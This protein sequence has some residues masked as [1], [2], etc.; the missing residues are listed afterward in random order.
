MNIEQIFIFYCQKNFLLR[1]NSNCPTWKVIWS[2]KVQWK[3]G[4]MKNQLWCEKKLK[5][6]EVPEAVKFR[7]S[8]MQATLVR[9]SA[10]PVLKNYH[11]GPL[12]IDL[13]S[14]PE[15]DSAPSPTFERMRRAGS[16]PTRT[17]PAPGFFRAAASRHASSTTAIPTTIHM[18]SSTQVNNNNIVTKLKPPVTTTSTSKLTSKSKVTEQ[19]KEGVVRKHSTRIVLDSNSGSRPSSSSSSTNNRPVQADPK[20]APPSST[21]KTNL[22]RCSITRTIVNKLQPN[23]TKTKGIWPKM[24][25]SKWRSRVKPE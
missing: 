23:T 6:L 25:F 24:N 16:T 13:A 7:M 21:N 18:A 19:A 11:S 3:N 5:I 20:P 15:N 12:S 8:P 22:A 10:L 4:R 9:P 1:R 17:I 2:H 14:S